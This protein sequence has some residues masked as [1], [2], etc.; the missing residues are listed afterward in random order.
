MVEGSELGA[1][2][3]NA[4]ER[5]RATGDRPRGHGA[6]PVRTNGQPQEDPHGQ[7]EDAARALPR[8]AQGHL[9]RRKEDPHRVAEDGEGGAVG[10][11]KAAFEKHEGETEQQ[12]TRLEQV[13]KAIDAKPKGKTCD[14]I[15]GIIEEGKEMMKEYKGRGAR[16]RPARR[17][18]GGRA[19]RDLALRYAENLGARTR[20]R[21]GRQAARGDAHGREEDRRGADQARRERGQPARA[22]GLRRTAPALPLSL[23]QG[24]RVGVR[25]SVR[26]LSACG[27]TPHP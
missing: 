2:A 14:A 13:F 11:L 5:P 25:G 16:R 10:R 15:M 18:A 19:L 20:L 4:T 24:E 27:S 21:G 1:R 22:G 3:L 7:G 26:E 6:L 8:H 17:R 23:L 9:L 12:V